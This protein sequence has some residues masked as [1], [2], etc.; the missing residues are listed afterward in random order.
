MLHRVSVIFV[1]FILPLL[2]ASMAA[3]AWSA[4]DRLVAIFGIA[5]I[6][7]IFICWGLSSFLAGPERREIARHMTNDERNQLSRMGGYFGL[8]V[9]LFFA[10]PIASAAVLA[11][12]ASGPTLVAFGIVFVVGL[13]VGLPILHHQ[14]KPIRAFLYHTEYAK[15]H[16]PRSTSHPAADGG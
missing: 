6:P 5:V 15:R 12:Y 1:A 11:Y 16:F 14:S 9:G 2:L 8:K 3:L 13:I 10:A 4:G 7:V